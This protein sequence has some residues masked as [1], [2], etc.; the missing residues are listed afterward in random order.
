MKTTKEYD[1]LIVGAGL[2]G[3]TFARLA[4][5]RGLRCLIIDKR[6]H[7]GGNIYCDSIEGI[8]VHRYGAHIFHTSNPK[9]WNFVNSFVPFNNFRN[10][11]IALAPDGKLYNLPFNM[12]TF[13]R[14]WDTVTPEG[15]LEKI[16][17]Q[18]MEATIDKPKNLEEQALKLVGADIYNLLIK[19]YTQ[20]QWG[21]PCSELPASIIRRLPV[22]FT[23]D[24]NY[25]N[26]T[27]QGIPVGG[28]NL[29]VK[30]LLV[31]SDLRLGIDF[32][33][34]RPFWEAKAEKIVFTG[35]I[36][37]FYNYRF[38]KLEY[39]TL[40]FETEVLEKANFQGNAVVNYTSEDVAFTRI[41]E[42]KHFETFN[43]AVYQNPKTVITR[44]Y[45]AEWKAGMDPFY[46]ISDSR[47]L[48]VFEQYQKLAAAEKNVV[49]GGRLAEYKYYDMAPLIA[50]ARR[51]FKGQ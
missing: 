28:Y 33:E 16:T 48:S 29:L 32:F 41:I 44:E 1:Y 34:N 21:R 43:D 39:R 11:P 18:R 4:T 42:H 2:Y 23:Y 22:R 47:N 35:C 10:S 5:D 30:A 19:G 31:G 24:N 49:F 25:F 7:F 12:N 3:A 20:K 37:E 27:Y 45:P 51:L 13:V 15:A 8:N 50:N 6:N 36:D 9:V 40:R 14:L 26:D 46:P 17:R 38:G